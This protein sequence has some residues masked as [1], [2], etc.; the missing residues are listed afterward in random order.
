[1]I[2]ALKSSQF[3]D[4]ELD[5]SCCIA[6]LEAKHRA[7]AILHDCPQVLPAAT[8]LFNQLTALPEASDLIY[9][10]AGP[11]EWL[12]CSIK[13]LIEA[14]AGAADRSGHL[15]R[16]AAKALEHAGRILKHQQGLQDG[17]E[18]G[19]EKGHE[20]GHEQGHEHGHEAGVK[21]GYKGGYQQHVVE[22]VA[23]RD[24]NLQK[25]EKAKSDKGSVTRRN[26]LDCYNQLFAERGNVRGIHA[27]IGRRV[28]VSRQRVVQIMEE[29]RKLPR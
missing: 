14:D 22:T 23:A 11:E 4:V 20:Q 17:Y 29:K 25:A 2:A 27:E 21:D 6:L 10:Q 13:A 12:A 15:E 8:Q 5:G 16:Y 19:H 28:G 3:A 18:A 7:L 24:A 9:R 26:V 1:M